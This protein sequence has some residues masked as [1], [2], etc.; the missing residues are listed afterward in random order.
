MSEE[1]VE[2][3][4]GDVYEDDIDARPPGNLLAAVKQATAQHGKAES[5]EPRSERN[6]R[7]ATTDDFDPRSTLHRDPTTLED[8]ELGSNEFEEFDVEGNRVDKNPKPPEQSGAE[9][10]S[11]PPVP[12]VAAD[13]LA[14]VFVLAKA[15]GVDLAA[16]YRTPADAVKG[17]LHAHKLVGQ[18]SESAQNWDDF[19][20]NPARQ[21]EIYGRLHEIYGTPPPVQAPAPAAAAPAVA[22]AAAA[23]V[24][25]PKPPTLP[26][27]W[28]HHYADGQPKPNADPNVIAA[29][30]EVRADRLLQQEDPAAHFEK[31]FGGEVEARAQKLVDEKLAAQ[32]KLRAEAADKQRLE[33]EQLQQ[34]EQMKSTTL[35]RMEQEG[36]FKWLYEPGYQVRGGNVEGTLT[37]NGEVFNRFL[38]EAAKATEHGVSLYPTAYQRAMYARE[39]LIEHASANGTAPTNGHAAP[40]TDARLTREPGGSVAP[41][42]KPGEYPPGWTLQQKIAHD[43][44]TS[45]A[46]LT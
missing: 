10:D 46:V 43:L 20:S 9:P 3:T 44:R 39:K 11:K 25:R 8:G 1:Q 41:A 6:N 5:A 28:Q 27:G 17:L 12:P 24:A 13:P 30:E 4:V 15:E 19:A 42:A 32:D 36:W 40:Q 22:T 31:W 14:E 18:R 21:R 33:Q 35:G 2:E 23:P 38:A 29:V 34:V 16:K 45:G 7:Q 26:K 37:P